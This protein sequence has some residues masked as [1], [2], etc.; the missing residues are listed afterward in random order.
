M[1]R[2]VLSP[3]PVTSM[4][5]SVVQ[6]MSGDGTRGSGAMPADRQG[7][8]QRVPSHSGVRNSPMATLFF[9]GTVLERHDVLN[10]GR[11]DGIQSVYVCIEVVTALCCIRQCRRGDIFVCGVF[12]HVEELGQGADGRVHVGR[13]GLNVHVAS[14][15]QCFHRFAG[16][17]VPRRSAIEVAVH[18]RVAVRSRCNVR[19]WLD[20]RHVPIVVE[21]FRGTVVFVTCT[22]IGPFRGIVQCC[23][24]VILRGAAACA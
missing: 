4:L 15:A 14:C 11:G 10:N 16:Q 1:R 6:R 12:E 2:P 19:P 3:W 18:E 9:L 13:H 21:S 22:R 17:C 20:G 8:K 23:L 7:A 5:Q 24:P